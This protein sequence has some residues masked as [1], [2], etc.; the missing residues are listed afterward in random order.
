MYKITKIFAREIL[1]SRGEPSVEAVACDVKNTAVASVP[2]G[3]STGTNEACELRD[4][5]LNR[6]EG[7][8]VLKAIANVNGVINES[9]RGSWDSLAEIDERLI[10]LDGTENKSRLGANAI[11]ATSL[12]CA[13]LFAQ[14]ENKPLYV[15][16]REHFDFTNLP[17][18][19]PTPLANVINGGLHADSNLDVQELWLIPSNNR[20]YF[21]QLRLVAEVFHHLGAILKEN[22]LSTNVGAEGGYAP[23]FNNTDD[24]WQYMVKAV[25][26]AKYNLG[27]DVYF[28]F[29]AGSSVWKKNDKY[30]WPKANLTFSASELK[31]KY[32]SWLGRYPFLA[33]EDPFAE[34]DWSAWR[35]FKQTLKAINH[36]LVLIGDDLF[37]TNIKRLQMGLEKDAANAILIKPNQ[38]GT[39]SE[40]IACVKKA[41]ASNW[42][43]VVSHRS[44]ETIDDF[45]ADLAVAVGADFVKFGAPS[46]SE[47]LAKYNRLLVIESELEKS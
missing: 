31:D 27:V 1:D 13:R 9:L 45:I 6:Y 18:K 23:R 32:I 38:I 30:H 28:G 17:W 7:K 36:D 29:D 46:R 40:T 3:A 44:G 8:G 19:M 11:L 42:K 43:T 22:N 5:D 37:T 20:N 4:H 12:A 47:R 35:D 15:F 25:A 16:L 2:A 21:E 33:I 41:Q 39:L 34:N 10:Y 26:S 24:A 14:Q